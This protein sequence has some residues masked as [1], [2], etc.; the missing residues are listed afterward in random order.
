MVWRLGVP[1]SRC[2]Q[3]RCTALA[4]FLPSQLSTGTSAVLAVRGPAASYAAHS[5]STLCFVSGACAPGVSRSGQ[6]PAL[7]LPGACTAPCCSSAVCPVWLWCVPCV[8][9]GRVFAVCGDPSALVPGRLCLAAVGIRRLL[10]CWAFRPALVRARMCTCTRARVCMHVRAWRGGGR[11]GFLAGLPAGSSPL[12]L[13][14]SV[15][16]SVFGVPA[17][18]AWRSAE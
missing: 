10:A 17:C 3:L 14:A 9:C 13:L 12:S 15:W 4:R 5:C 16:L 11:S 8:R 6:R 7:A 18:C 1:R 2:V